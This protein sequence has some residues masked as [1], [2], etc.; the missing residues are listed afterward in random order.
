MHDTL[1]TIVDARRRSNPIAIG[2]LI[3]S[4][5]LKCASNQAT[6]DIYD[7]VFYKKSTFWT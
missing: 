5:D 7:K 2:H 1:R 6:V 3:D 4:I